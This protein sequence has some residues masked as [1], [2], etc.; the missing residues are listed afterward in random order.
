M[1]SALSELDN[2]TGFGFGRA[3]K[4]TFKYSLFKLRH[5]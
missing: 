2:M 5:M 3:K 4:E 1:L